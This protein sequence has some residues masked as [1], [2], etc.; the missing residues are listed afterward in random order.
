MTTTYLIKHLKKEFELL[1]KFDLSGE[2][3]EFQRKDETHDP[4]INE[5][6]FSQKMFPYN[7]ERMEIWKE[8]LTETF[9]VQKSPADLSFENLWR[10]YNYKIA[11][12]DA[13]KAFNKLSKDD[14]IKCFLGVKPY[15]QHLT[16]TKTGKAHLSRYINGRYFENEY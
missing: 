12:A 6:L 9:S 8:K 2:L 13:I 16:K 1:L 11:K 10:I 3:I 4:R 15:E 7:L 5:W 14:V